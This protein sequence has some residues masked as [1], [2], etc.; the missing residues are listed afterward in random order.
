MNAKKNCA[1]WC[2]HVKYEKFSVIIL[3]LKK[4]FLYLI[5]DHGC[6]ILITLT[7][8]HKSKH[9][10]KLFIVRHAKSD[11]SFFGNDFER[12]LNERGRS[13]APVMAKK[14]S[15]KKYE[16]DVLISSPAVRAKQTAES[17]A[18]ILKMPAKDIIFISALY[19][20]APEVFYEVI[21]DLS[22]QFETVAIFSHNPGITHFVNSLD[23]AV[24]IDN[25]PTCAIF[26]VSADTI[27]WS[28]FSKA[29]RK[30]LFFDHP[31]KIL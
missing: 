12:P 14:L 26:A 7:R 1:Y 4:L 13:D 9:L 18:D 25:M 5:S 21:A 24:Q 15:D 10:K 3:L 28:G 2:L 23:P 20:A 30:F 29:K 6:F 27:N 31:K 8:P 11:Q 19:H 22:D 16:I 17:F